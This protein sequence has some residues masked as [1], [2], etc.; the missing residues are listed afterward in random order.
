MQTWT[1]QE[2]QVL[3]TPEVRQLLAPTVD[4]A[5]DSDADAEATSTLPQRAVSDVQGQRPASPVNVSKDVETNIS[6]EKACCCFHPQKTVVKV[7]DGDN[8]SEAEFSRVKRGLRRVNKVR[9]AP[10]KSHVDPLAMQRLLDKPGL[11][12]VLEAMQFYRSKRMG[13]IGWSPHAFGNLKDDHS[14]LWPRKKGA[15]RAHKHPKRGCLGFIG[16]ERLPVMW[17]L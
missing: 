11:E 6:T 4:L 2:I 14:W 15:S 12:T 9:L 10:A 1:K 16:D 17:G 8:F 13:H 5:S 7:L 3:D